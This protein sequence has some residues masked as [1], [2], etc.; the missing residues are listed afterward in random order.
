M[1]DLA[2]YSMKVT[3]VPDP[4]MKK[5]YA[6]GAFETA[7]YIYDMSRR[8]GDPDGIKRFIEDEYRNAREHLHDAIMSSCMLI[9]EKD[10]NAPTS[11]E[12]ERDG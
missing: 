5:V 10:G 12:G 3:K 1:S 11:E 8:I 9:V 6:L 2:R 7:Q 4:E